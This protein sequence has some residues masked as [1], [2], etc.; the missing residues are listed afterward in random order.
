MYQHL[1]VRTPKFEL[2]SVVVTDK[3][4]GNSDDEGAKTWALVL[5]IIGVL[6]VVSPF[7]VGAT[8]SGWIL[9]GLFVGGLFIVAALGV[10]SD[11]DL[12]GPPIRRTG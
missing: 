2:G 10:A 12:D 4:E 11:S 6:V 1:T 8:T 5:G 7:V 9:L 3:P